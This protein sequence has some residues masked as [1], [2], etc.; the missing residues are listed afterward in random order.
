ME[1][2]SGGVGGEKEC[3]CVCVVQVWCVCAW[4]AGSVTRQTLLLS[5]AL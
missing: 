4:L 2:L 1:P 3:V 5:W